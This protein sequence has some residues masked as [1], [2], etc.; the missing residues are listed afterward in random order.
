MRAASSRQKSNTSRTTDITWMK[1]RILSNVSANL[2]I[3]SISYL[4]SFL[5]VLYC[6]RVLLPEGYGRA[7]FAAS[8]AGYFTMLAQMGMPIYAMRSCAEA[9][10]DKAE[11][12]KVVNELWSI[13]AVLSVISAGL[14]IL[15]LCVCPELRDHKELIAIYGSAIILQALGFDWLYR[16]MEK[17]RF[18]A[19]SMLVCK[20]ISLICIVAFV[21]SPE[22]LW[23]YAA[24]SV[25]AAHGNSLICFVALPRYVNIDARIRVKA[26]HFRPLLVFFVMSMAVTVYSSLDLT[27]LGLMRTDLE[28]GLYSVAS[29]GKGILTLIGGIVWSSALP[30]AAELWKNGDRD[31][32]A[33]L[34]RK[35]LII[36]CG[37]QMMVM[38]VCMVY[39]RQ[40]MLVI[41]G[42]SYVDAVP[43]FRILLLC[44]VPIGL[45][46]ILGGQVL[47]PS[48][49]EKMLLTAEIAGAVLNFFAN[50]III[51]RFSLEGAAATT[52]AAEVSVCALCAYYIKKKL[53]MDLVKESIKGCLWRVC[54]IVNRIYLRRVSRKH[55]DKLPFYCP[56]CDTYLQSFGKGGYDSKPSLYNPERYKYTDQYVVCPIC[57]AIPRH[58]ILAEWMD[59]NVGDIRGKRILHFAQERS[60]RKWLDRNGVHATTA[61]LYHAADLRLNIEDTGLPDSS[62]DMIICNHVLEHVD[63]YKS[64]LGEIRRILSHEGI[65]VISMPYDD[66]IETVYEDPSIVKRED[67]IKHF[68]QYD[69]LRVFGRDTRD[70]IRAFGFKVADITSDNHRI[71]PVIG[72]ADYDYNVLW[73]LSKE[74]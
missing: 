67:R 17:F 7:S 20:A 15:S 14:L 4:F 11:L 13:N 73:C 70:L 21:H 5:T 71:K 28:T 72:P 22:Q 74:G 64:A 18:I 52:V 66:R 54:R 32:F 16:G 47:I 57:G 38:V 31:G 19:A 2:F 30:R 23:I 24:L 49:N 56:C 39:A 62:Y 48:G 63:N 9:R 10:D 6:T 58:R 51:P 12:S 26:K 41:G 69:H 8:I 65:A 25:F 34:A 27:M 36:V 68:G 43:S 45:S 35:S 1:S 50:L 61:D 46:N 55:R 44:L 29:K 33:S 42:G 37:I 40:I 53:G 3:K 60:I 59:K